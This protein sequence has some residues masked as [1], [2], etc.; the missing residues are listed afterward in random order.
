MGKRN[1]LLDLPDDV[2]ANVLQRCPPGS[3]AGFPLPLALAQVRVTG[4]VDPHWLRPLLHLACKCPVV[5]DRLTPHLRSI[6]TLCRCCC[7]K[8]LASITA[9]LT[10]LYEVVVSCKVP[11]SLLVSLPTSLT[12]LSLRTLEDGSPEALSASLLRL[13]A[14]EDLDLGHLPWEDPWIVGGTLPRLERLMVLG[15]LPEDLEQMAPKL[16]ALNAWVNPEDLARLP[17]TLTELRFLQCPFFR[18]SLLP[19][20]RLRGLRDLGTPRG[21]DFADLAEL[22]PTLPALSKLELRVDVT[23][24]NLPQLVE[25]VDRGPE[26]LGLRLARIIVGSGPARW[27]RLFRH[28]LG[29]KILC[30]IDPDLLPWAALNRLARL[31]LWA[32]GRRDASWVQPLS[33]LPSLRDLDVRLIGQVPAGFGALTQCTR[34][35]LDG[36]EGDQLSGLRRLTRLRD[37]CIQLPR[38]DCVPAL[39]HGLTKLRLSGSPPASPDLS[40]GQALQH[41]TNLMHLSIDWPTGEAGVCDLAPLHQLERLELKDAP[42]ALVRLSG[43]PCLKVVHLWKCWDVDDN[44]LHQLRGL[45]SLTEVRLDSDT[46]PQEPP[47]SYIRAQS[48]QGDLSSCRVL[49]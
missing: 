11:V 46:G 43:L 36:H 4:S 24:G 22:L 27:E 2:L 40:L 21:L 38:I 32:K 35:R 1:S 30:L 14:L 33:Q 44:L 34:L 15:R 13:T 16:E 12:K 45:P 8:D 28:L 9:R 25:A 42:C 41:L 3:I 18:S 39:P 7:I 20:T 23:D 29:A 10:R 6:N 5:L 49:R 19:L 48:K 31:E 17:G 47:R 26:G 37:C